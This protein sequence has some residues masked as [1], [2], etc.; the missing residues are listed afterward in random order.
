GRGGAVVVAPRVPAKIEPAVVFDPG[1]GG[2]SSAPDAVACIITARVEV[3]VAATSEEPIGVHACIVGPAVQPV[4]AVLAE[5]EVT[6][7]IADQAVA[8]LSTP[9]VVVA[10]ERT[11]Y[12]V[13]PSSIIDV[14]A[15]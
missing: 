14:P 10:L 1:I 15:R 13:K 6:A 3:V 11:D 4:R 12:V 9:Q 7:R 2:V 8:A 5:H